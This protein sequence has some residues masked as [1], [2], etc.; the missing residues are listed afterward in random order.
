VGRSVYKVIA[1]SAMIM[2]L[3][4][5]CAGKDKTG[6]ANHTSG[7]SS[8]TVRNM[9]NGSS[10]TSW[11][12]T[13][14]DGAETMQH[15]EET[16]IQAGTTN[17][18]AD[19]SMQLIQS[20]STDLD[21]DGDSE[22]VEIFQKAIKSASGD[23]AGE[24]E[25]IMRITGK[26]G[27]V[28]IS[29]IRKPAGLTEVMSSLEIRDLDSD[30]VKDIFLVLPD[31]GASFSLNYFYIYN[32]KTGKSYTYTSDNNLSDF[33]GSFRFI[34]K[35]K[36]ALDIINE[37]YKFSASFDITDKKYGPGPDDEGN[38]EYANAWVDPAP[39]EIGEN[40]RLV[41]ANATDGNAEVKVPL[42][43]FG[44]SATDMIGEVD[45][46]YRVDGNFEPV[47]EHFTVI[48][49]NDGKLEKIGEWKKE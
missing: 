39:V 5:S 40:S 16:D 46:Y 23:E 7:I 12:P 27:T 32:Y 6:D 44:V 37:R 18:E 28:E 22:Q 21:G 45:L 3:S 31:A 42:P 8:S 26:V 36:G 48:D 47:L 11:I 14:P 35:G 33:T 2:I 15:P 41:L 9:Q 17:N 24:L 20:A 49:F 13:G 4:A 1:L 34:Y 30:G 29:F 43:V 38:E 10:G 25:G 19:P